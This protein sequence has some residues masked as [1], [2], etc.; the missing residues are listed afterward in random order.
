MMDMD[1]RFEFLNKYYANN[2]E[3]IYL[4]LKIY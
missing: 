1:N 3:K 4:L 2:A